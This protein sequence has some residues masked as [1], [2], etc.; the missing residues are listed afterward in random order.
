VKQDLRVTPST[1]SRSART[2][3]QVLRALAVAGVVLNHLF[4]NRL[5]GGYLG[6]DI[7][8]VISG[9]LI[10][11]HLVSEL[12]RDDHVA[13]GG[14]YARRARRLL[15][16]SL[17]VLAVCAVA[18]VTWIPQTRWPQI[19]DEILASGL[20]FQ[21]W[22]LV[23][24]AQDYFTS[25]QTPS[26]VTHFWSLSVEEQFYLVWPVL[27]FA[28]WWL[29]GRAGG[30]GPVPAAAVRRRVLAAA[31]GV[32]GLASMAFSVWALRS[33]PEAAYFVTPGRVWEFAVGGVLGTFPALRRIPGWL[34]VPGWAAMVGSMWFF[35]DDAGVPGLMTLIPVAGCALVIRAGAGS[36]GRP[37]P[38]ALRGPVWVGD[39][40]YSIYLWHWPLIIFAPYALARPMTP[41][42]GLAL[43]VV[44]LGLSQLSARFIERPLRTAPV[45]VNRH[46]AVT[47][48]GAGVCM[49]LLGGAAAYVPTTVAGNLEEVQ[50]RLESLLEDGGP[51][52]GAPAASR[53]CPDSHKLTIANSDLVNIVNS[54]YLPKW[55]GTCQVEPEDP[56]PAPC[57][58][59]VPREAAERRIALVGDSHAGHWASALDVV[60]RER[61]WNVT[62]EVKSSCLPTPGD[63]HAGWATEPM[64]VSCKSWGDDVRA[65][66]SDDPAIDV[67]VMSGISRAYTSADA[68]GTVAQL[69]QLWA[70][71]VRAGK[72]V[73]V[74]ADPPDLGRGPLP[75]C[76]AGASSTQDPCAARTRDVLTPDPL[77][78]AASGQDGVTLVDLT[79]VMCDSRRCHAV[80]GGI[81][82][83][84]DD[85]HL[86]QY[87]ARTM[88]PLLEDAMTDLPELSGTQG[89]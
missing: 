9:F 64:I 62:M 80:V 60:A 33:H 10:T 41:A 46:S 48:V 56:Q 1:T 31:L 70:Q 25:A 13:L 72:R 37:V 57:A 36:G 15:P 59:G 22:Q 67:I 83:Y 28:V 53:S 14:F 32:L 49:A 19:M 65:E 87:F 76:L 61:A 39:I 23:A 34:A 7:F 86:L 3:I 71:W 20:Y 12:E 54:P 85:S 75:E 84:G 43:L 26:P 11:S 8:F 38:L 79:D 35:G 66:L 51:C 16:A 2:D 58:F 55:G 18:T 68:D 21:N 78:E 88:A 63:S 69:R 45:L 77:V 24:S 52:V 74:L 89:R 73:V 30:A 47:L 17:T 42:L 4:P 29:A 82:V 44:T 6:V 50:A 40:S 5:T 81:P 27:T